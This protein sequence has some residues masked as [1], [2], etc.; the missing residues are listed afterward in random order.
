MFKKLQCVCLYTKDMEKSR[1]CK[2]GLNIGL[3]D[4]NLI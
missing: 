1:L 4:P 3:L 2:K